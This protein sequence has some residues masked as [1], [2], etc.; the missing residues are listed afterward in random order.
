MG[1]SKDNEK[2]ELFDVAELE[3]DAKPIKQ[4]PIAARENAYSS[5][6]R[7]PSASRPM[8]KKKGESG[9]DI[10]TIALLIVGGLILLMM[11]LLGVFFAIRYA[12]PRPGV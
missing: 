8:P 4:R 2:E 6:R 9:M 1:K 12:I 3:K 11:L 7:S 10:R 5:S